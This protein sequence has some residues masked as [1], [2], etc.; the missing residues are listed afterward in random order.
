MS[1]DQN[2]MLL[3]FLFF[4]AEL[5]GRGLLA[6]RSLRQRDCNNNIVWRKYLYSTG[7]G[8]TVDHKPFIKA[9]NH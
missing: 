8:K 6:I 2:A 3:F 7:V 9:V 1:C 5:E 4:F